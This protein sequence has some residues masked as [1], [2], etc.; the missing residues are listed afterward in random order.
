MER[1]ETDITD[2]YR[3]KRKIRRDINQI[4]F[5]LEETGALFQRKVLVR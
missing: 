3:E 2:I 4:I 1:E 5:T